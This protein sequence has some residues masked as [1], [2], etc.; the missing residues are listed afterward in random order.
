MTEKKKNKKQTK[1]LPD[2]LLTR[3][4]IKQNVLHGGE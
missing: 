3:E 4:E 2:F 1:N